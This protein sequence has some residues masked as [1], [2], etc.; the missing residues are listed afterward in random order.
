MI[1]QQA[2]WRR[3]YRHESAEHKNWDL[4]VRGVRDLL[5][6]L[7]EALDGVILKKT[8][9]PVIDLLAPMSIKA[10]DRRSFKASIELLLTD[11]FLVRT[12]DDVL[13]IRNFRQAQTGSSAPDLDDSPAASVAMPAPRS[14]T[15]ELSAARAEAG[16]RGGMKA[17]A[18]KQLASS[19]V[20]QTD[21]QNMEQLASSKPSNLLSR[22]PE[23]QRRE[24]EKSKEKPAL[25][26][27]DQDL[28]RTDGTADG[29]SEVG[30]SRRKSGERPR[31]DALTMGFAPTTARV[32]SIP[33]SMALYASELGLD[34]NAYSDIVTDWREKVVE[35]QSPNRLISVLFRFIERKAHG[36]PQEVVPPAERLRREQAGARRQ[37]A[38]AERAA[39]ELA[40]HTERARAELRKSG[41][42]PDAPFDPRQPM[43][44]LVAG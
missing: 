16:R 18:S 22:D 32:F 29:L 37:A 33:D 39:R 13:L 19:K 34:A 23:D 38:M 17:Q 14:V 25:P 7:P 10:K 41:I 42:D 31:F 2:Q 12:E 35:P 24:E 5:M 43:A 9:D 3:Q 44:N 21:K 1:V 26:K 40:E 6:R 20:E 8:S 27:T 11:G 30:L 28:A 4:T 15:P 36:A